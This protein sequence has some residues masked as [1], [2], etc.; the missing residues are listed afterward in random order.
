MLDQHSDI[1]HTTQTTR[2]PYTQGVYVNVSVS[3]SDRITF[4]IQTNINHDPVIKSNT[5]TK[6]L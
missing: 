5:S 2:H 4:S 3:H 1:K 6:K